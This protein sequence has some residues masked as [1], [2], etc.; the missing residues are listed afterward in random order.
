MVFP[1]SMT[2]ISKK[3]LIFSRKTWTFQHLVFGMAHCLMDLYGASLKWV[4]KG[5]HIRIDSSELL[6]ILRV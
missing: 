1:R 3:I 5:H 6:V 2:D 4:G